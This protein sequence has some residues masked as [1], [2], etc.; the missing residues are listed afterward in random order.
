MSPQPS[1]GHYRIVSKLGEGGMGAVYRATDTRLNR[2]VALKVLTEALANDA[3]YLARFTREAQVLASLNHP[4]IAQIYGIEQGA[5]VMELVEG[6][7]LDGQWPIETVI[8]YGRQIA[9]ALEAAHEKGVIHRDL[10]PANIKVTPEGVI[11][12]LDFGL[13]KAIEPTTSASVANSPTLTLRSTQL[14]VTMGTAGYMAPEQAAGKPVDKR[15]DIW[16]YG[17]VLY[18]ML[19]GASLFTGET[20][21]HTL[22]DVLRAPIDL[23][24]LPADTPSHVRALIERC[25]DRTLKT[26]LRDI[27]EARIALSRPIA[28]A[29]APTG[30]TSSK[31]P[32]IA[33]GVLTVVAAGAGVGWWRA[34]RPEPKQVMRFDVNLGRNARAGQ[35]TSAHFSPDGSKILFPAITTSGRTGLFVRP[36]DQDAATPLSGSD[37]AVNVEGGFS[38]DGQ[39]VA[40][41]VNGMIRKASVGGGV[42]APICADTGARGITWT[43]DGWVIYAAIDGR[44]KRVRDSG[45]N[46]ETLTDPTSAEE[47]AHLWPALLPGGK[48]LLYTAAKRLNSFDDSELRLLTIDSRTSVTVARGAFFARY[49]PTGHLLY[50]RGSTLYAARWDPRRPA[51]LGTPVA[52][53]DNIAYDLLT[54]GAHYSIAG[55]GSMVYL[56]GNAA[57][58]TRFAWLDP[59][60]SLKPL[61]IPQGRLSAPAI[62]PD[63]RR[64]AYSSQTATGTD[65]W[66]YD[67]ERDA[68]TQLTFNQVRPG[69]ELAWSPDSR[70]I[71]FG[72]SLKNGGALWWIRADGS[73]EPHRLLEA[74]LVPRPQSISPDGRT[75]LYSIAPGGIP[76]LLSV[77]L[78]LADPDRPKAGTPQVFLQ[79]PLVEIDGTFSPDGKWVAYTGYDSGVAEIFV[80]P[81]PAGSNGGGKFHVSTNGGK[82]P[83]WTPKD[84]RLFFV[85]ADNRIE[86]VTYTVRGENFEASKPQVWSEQPIQRDGVIRPFHLHPDGKRLAV[87]PGTKDD[88]TQN[89]GLH[90]QVVLNFFEELKRRVP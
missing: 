87:M 34:S 79:T 8:D 45:G 52:M 19:T 10:K 40:F 30:R 29:L 16:S 56:P 83:M 67:V 54:G 44:M 47:V 74:S 63:G 26:R 73:G 62:S 78:D 60:G 11:K 53:V 43:G 31:L 69:S 39:W 12:V 89:A 86:F 22:A 84:H 82:F 81:F 71:V 66:A 35:R 41:F 80:R 70:H 55:N 3:D 36:L 23:S 4:N 2:D 59:S 90:V 5:I 77:S 50:M 18:E 46:P 88:P 33:A 21:A 75:L 38:P 14:G 17:V 27:G 76:D 15:A 28:A 9:E 72:A 61:A 25:L 6:R 7:T 64:V 68:T 1:I 20:I 85:G 37:A 49:A 51:E 58:G 13:A 32:W 24:K 65:I 57:V 42:A 48:Q